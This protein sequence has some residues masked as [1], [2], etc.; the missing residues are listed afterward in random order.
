MEV[1]D[2]PINAGDDDPDADRERERMLR[3]FNDHGY[4]ADI[5]ALRRM[6]PGLLSLE[7]RARAH[8]WGG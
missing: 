4:E 3:W 6:H 8:G 2:V 7:G 5:Q 1:Q